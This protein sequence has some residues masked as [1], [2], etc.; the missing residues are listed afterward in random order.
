[1]GQLIKPLI[2]VGLVGILAYLTLFKSGKT[3]ARSI[4]GNFM[5]IAQST[6]DLIA[7]FEK[8]SPVP[9][10]DAGGQSIGF[11]HFIQPGESYASID[12]KTAL[13]LL[14][15]DTAGAQST[16]STLVKVPLARNQIDALVSL[17]Y[18]IGASNF[19]KST[20]L[21]KLNVSD[22]TGA[23]DQFNVWNKTHINGFL[24]VSDNLI[25]RRSAER[26]LFLS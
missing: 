14:K 12:L 20:L 17:V 16:V 9:Y 6:L 11:G 1:M 2:L 19:K 8:F 26:L 23:A 21:R 13:D 25:K 7:D 15:R 24:V 5:D 18:N 22:Y 4:G 10:K 3:L